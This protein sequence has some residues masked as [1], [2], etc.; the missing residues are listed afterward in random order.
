M[1]YPALVVRGADP[2]F[3]LAI[4]D[5]FS[6]TAVEETAEG[7]S[8]FFTSADRRASAHAA[9]A[10]QFPGAVLSLRD[11][12]DEDWARR[13]QQ[14]LTAIVIGRITVTPPWCEPIEV[15][16]STSGEASS[17]VITINPSMGFGTGHHATTRLCLAAL[18]A[19]EV[20]GRRVL[21]VG[22]GSGVLAIAAARLGASDVRGIDVDPDA[23]ASARENLDL[24]PDAK[25]VRLETADLRDAGLAQAD[26]V[27]ANLTGAVLIGTASLLAGAVA[28]GGSLIVS[29]LQ[30]HE[31]ADVLAAFADL[32][33]SSSAEDGEWVALTFNRPTLGGV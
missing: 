22:T 27:L 28:P 8:I 24:N 1:K 9:L 17:I 6:P 18:Q 3:V 11:V 29:G 4:V 5:D 32:Q 19:I 12:D 33:L 13:S 30:V 31:R 16:R 7:T 25:P 26:I 2:D 14:N 20:H 15:E 10:A 21:D 23:V